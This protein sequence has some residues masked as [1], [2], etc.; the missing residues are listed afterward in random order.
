MPMDFDSVVEKNGHF[1][2]FETKE[3]GKEIE[4][5]QSITLTNMWK[6]DTTIVHVAGK[7]PETI[8]GF[9]VYGEWESPK[10]GNV[11]DRGINEGDAFDLIFSVRRWFCW[12]LG[13]EMPS[14]EEWDREL[15]VWDYGRKTA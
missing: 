14:R 13:T 11:G 8:S 3:E 6:K 1:L 12:S 15:W 4:K 10:A 2:I 7:T 9:S 5:G